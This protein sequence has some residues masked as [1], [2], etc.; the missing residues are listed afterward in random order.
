VCSSDLDKFPD[1]F[2]WVKDRSHMFRGV[3]LGTIIKDIALS[4]VK[5]GTFL[6]RADNTA[7]IL[8]VKYHI[9][10][11][12]VND[13]GGSADYYQWGSLLRSVSAF[14]AYRK[15]YRDVISPLRVAEL[16]ILRD[17]MPRSLH[18]CMNEVEMALIDINGNSGREARRRAGRQHAAL[19][20]GS[21]EDVVA[22]GLHEY[23]TEFLDQIA[24]LG[25]DIRAAY[26]SRR[27]QFEPVQPRWNGMQMQ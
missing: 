23:L 19:H 4:F 1:F 17:D 26:L 10:L 25:Q 22:Q 6:E 15:I 9:L 18:A 8:D 21:I 13:V 3:T 14:E 24:L 11:P 7:R 5:L 2:D 16:L 12:S 27:D 20:F